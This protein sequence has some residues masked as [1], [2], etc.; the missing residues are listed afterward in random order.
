MNKSRVLLAF[1]VSFFALT[2][3][4]FAQTEI[5]LGPRVG[6]E[7]DTY[8]SFLIGA[9]VR[10]A[11]PSLP[12]RINPTLDYFFVDDDYSGGASGVD[13]S[14]TVFQLGVNALYDLPLPELSFMPY[15]GAGIALT[16]A[17][18]ELDVAG[19]GS[20]ENSDTEAGINLIGGL[21]FP[22]NN[23]KPFVQ[24]QVTIG[25]P[26]LFSLVGGLLFSF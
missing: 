7:L 3:V 1:F 17:T 19:V 15:V 11:T 10:I 9:D 5:E 16:R 12:V 18:V 13:V 23:L 4:A 6:Y 14:V 22:T 2:S 20:G 25:D 24:V 21:T 8:E 26:D